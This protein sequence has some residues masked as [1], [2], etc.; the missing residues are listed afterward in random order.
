MDT[1]PVTVRVAPVAFSA[2][3]EPQRGPAPGSQPAVPAAGAGAV[4][5]AAASARS[6]RTAETS[7]P[8]ERLRS[9]RASKEDWW[10]GME[11]H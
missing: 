9:G 5:A 11:I 2:A 7:Q 4:L 8:P 10:S 6:L 3:H 1:Q